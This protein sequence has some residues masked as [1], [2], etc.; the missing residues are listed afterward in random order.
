MFNLIIYLSAMFPIIIALIIHAEREFQK[1]IEDEKRRE[2]KNRSDS[3][4]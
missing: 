4:S 2:E 1:D 3:N